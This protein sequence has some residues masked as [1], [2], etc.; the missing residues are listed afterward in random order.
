M[1]P[2]SPD[3]S[4]RTFAPTAFPTF[5]LKLSA[6]LIA[7]EAAIFMWMAMDWVPAYRDLIPRVLGPN[8]PLT[9]R[10]SLSPLW[11]PGL[12]VGLMGLTTLAARQESSLLR[13]QMAL[14]LVFWVGL[15]AIGFS[16]WATLTPLV[17]MGGPSGS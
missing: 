15:V 5:G 13:R 7:V 1:P 3:E 12:A 14:L 10:M 17:E 2:M 16:F 9:T 8:L 4:P 6:V 11:F